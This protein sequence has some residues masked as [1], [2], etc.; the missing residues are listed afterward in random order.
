M[1]HDLKVV[2]LGKDSAIG[3]AFVIELEAP[4]FDHPPLY[5]IGARSFLTDRAGATARDPCDFPG[6][7]SAAQRMVLRYDGAQRLLEGDGNLEAAALRGGASP[8][9]GST[10]A[11]LCWICARSSRTTGPTP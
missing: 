3:D 7:R 5:V 11:H 6:R 8:S 9:P 2:S 4:P 1:S 10:P